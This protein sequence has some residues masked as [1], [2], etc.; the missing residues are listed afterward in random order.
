MDGASLNFSETAMA[1]DLAILKT[2]RA[3]VTT[4]ESKDTKYV[5]TLFVNRGQR[6]KLFQDRDEAKAWLLK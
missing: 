5:E 6:V 4:E 2:K 3:V 1:S